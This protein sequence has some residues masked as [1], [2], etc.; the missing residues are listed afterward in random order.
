MSCSMQ[1]KTNHGLPRLPYNPVTNSLRTRAYF[2]LSREATA[3][4]TSVFAGYGTYAFRDFNAVLS[5]KFA[6]S[7]LRSTLTPLIFSSRTKTKISEFQVS[8][9]EDSLRTQ[10]YFQLSL[11]KREPEIR[12]RLQ[13]RMKRAC[14]KTG[15]IFTTHFYQR[16]RLT[17]QVKEHT[18]WKLTNYAFV[19]RFLPH[20]ELELEAQRRQYLVPRHNGI[21]RG[22]E[23]WVLLHIQSNVLLRWHR[24]TN[25]SLYLHQS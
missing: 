17:H 22:Q 2:R 3:G 13:A 4:N 5:A 1:K 10:T 24:C 25:G 16:P 19:A 14:L 15:Y 20:N 11:L 8:R 12:P 7:S 18:T 9:D 21:H 6:F 23:D